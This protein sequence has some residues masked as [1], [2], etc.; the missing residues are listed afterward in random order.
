MYGALEVTEFFP[1]FMFGLFF[2]TSD[3]VYCIGGNIS[4]EPARGKD[5]LLFTWLVSGS[6]SFVNM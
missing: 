4:F 6:L 3:L 2:K 5:G 1:S